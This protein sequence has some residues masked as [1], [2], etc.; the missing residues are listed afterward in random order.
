MIN[1]TKLII[2][3]LVVEAIGLLGGIF[4]VKSI[5]KWYSKLRK[6]RFNPP[7]RIFGPVW[8]ILYLM[9]G[10]SFYLIWTSDKS[11]Y[12]ASII[13]AIQLIFNFAWSG[14]FF[15]AHKPGLAFIEIIFLWL[16]IIATIVM[17]YPISQ[18]ASYLLVPYLLWVSFAS[19]LNFAIYWLNK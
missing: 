4:N 17:F 19:V 9:M 15:G 16:S 3:I 18:L 2:S 13:F 5:P 14:I 12:L 7:A 1:I 11:I 6:P 8:T 10:I